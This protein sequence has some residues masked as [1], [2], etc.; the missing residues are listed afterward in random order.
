MKRR[1]VPDMTQPFVQHPV[2]KKP[3]TLR[4]QGDFTGQADDGHVADAESDDEEPRPIPPITPCPSPRAKDDEDSDEEVVVVPSVSSKDDRSSVDRGNDEKML[5][6]F[7]RDVELDG[8]M[9]TFI[10][11]KR[12][13]KIVNLNIN[14]VPFLIQR[15]AYYY[16]LR[17]DDMKKMVLALQRSTQTVQ[18]V[19]DELDVSDLDI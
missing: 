9:F 5:T 6:T 17:G 18:K 15:L 11:V 1:S 2:E 7:Y 8:K 14:R 3:K 19:I 4:N 13:G 10:Y 12:N 16:S